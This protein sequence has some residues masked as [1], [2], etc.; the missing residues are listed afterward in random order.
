MGYLRPSRPPQHN[1]IR[2]LWG[3]ST[4]LPAPLWGSLAPSIDQT[5]WLLPATPSPRC[6]RPSPQS[7]L[8][9]EDLKPAQ[10]S[11]APHKEQAGFPAW[12]PE[13]RSIG[14]NC[15]PTPAQRQALHRRPLQMTCVA[16]TILT[17][18]DVKF[19]LIPVTPIP[20]EPSI[21]GNLQSPNTL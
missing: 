1:L 7:T 10:K 4:H 14:R 5:L 17:G 3:L 2:Q 15:L 11:N 18:P 12:A 21:R 19:I 6:R 8:S 9:C 13:P 20:H 16:L